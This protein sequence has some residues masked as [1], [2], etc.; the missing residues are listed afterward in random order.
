MEVEE[1]TQ[2]EEE[3]KQ[4]CNFRLKTHEEQLAGLCRGMLDYNLHLRGC[5]NLGK[6]S[7]LSP[8]CH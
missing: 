5:L 1:V 7:G 3:D 4:L 2:G 6:F 8:S